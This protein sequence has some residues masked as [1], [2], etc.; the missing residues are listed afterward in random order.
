MRLPVARE[1]FPTGTSAF[2]DGYNRT[3]LGMDLHKG[4]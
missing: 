4:A 3:A 2:V 1:I